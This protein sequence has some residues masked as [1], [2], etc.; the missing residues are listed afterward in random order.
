MF[1]DKVDNY[2]SRQGSEFFV[3]RSDSSSVHIR[4]D[5][6]SAL[7]RSGGTGSSRSSISRVWCGMV[8]VVISRAFG[9]CFSSKVVV[10]STDS[11]F[12]SKI[13]LH[14]GAIDG[15]STLIGI[16]PD[17]GVGIVILINTSQKGPESEKIMYRLI[18]D[19]LGLH[20]KSQDLSDD[21]SM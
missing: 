6:D 10:F 14:G 4:R 17:D 2:T 8:S 16:L 9:R 15:I 21:V 18:G 19:I 13:L 11:L 1:S 3:A 5:H 20:P 12:P 7:Y